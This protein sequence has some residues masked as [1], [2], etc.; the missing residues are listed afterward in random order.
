MEKNLQKQI[1][2]SVGLK[3]AVLLENGSSDEVSAESGVASVW[4]G[5]GDLSG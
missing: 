4:R 3:Q 1:C 5:R 2:H